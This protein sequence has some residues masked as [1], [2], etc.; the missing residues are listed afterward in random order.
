MLEL[1]ACVYYK[2]SICASTVRP[3]VLNTG[4]LAPKH[5]FLLLL[6]FLQLVSFDR[7]SQCSNPVT[8]PKNEGREDSSRQPYSGQRHVKQIQEMKIWKAY[9]CS[10]CL[11]YD[12]QSPTRVP[13]EFR[14]ENRPFLH[15]HGKRESASLASHGMVSQAPRHSTLLWLFFKRRSRSTYMAPW[16]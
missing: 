16:Q 8:L 7:V 13:S 6:V 9:L 12:G 11:F 5:L 15:Q 4:Q 2:P 3:T 1:T 14:Q 10:I